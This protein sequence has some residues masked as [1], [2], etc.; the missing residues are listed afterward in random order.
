VRKNY[1][2][3]FFFDWSQVENRKFRR[4][5]LCEFWKDTQR[6]VRQQIFQKLVKFIQTQNL[7]QDFSTGNSEAI[8]INSSQDREERGDQGSPF[9]DDYH[10][11]EPMSLDHLDYTTQSELNYL[12]AKANNA[13]QVEK[14][15]DFLTNSKID[16]CDMPFD[17][18]C[19]K[20]LKI[21]D[22]TQREITLKELLEDDE[23]SSKSKISK[24]KNSKA[25][26]SGKKEHRRCKSYLISP[27]ESK[28]KL[29]K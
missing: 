13:Y 28:G 15:I 27:E 1:L 26:K 19:R 9:D 8:G 14:F 25:G 12:I 11:E 18:I 29:Q 20:L 17:R 5:V 23:K 4:Q 24:Q 22:E 3:H 16:R 7:T 2:G 10:S 21:I 6:E